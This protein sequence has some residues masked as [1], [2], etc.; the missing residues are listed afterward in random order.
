[1][2]EPHWLGRQRFGSVARPMIPMKF[3]TEQQFSE[4]HQ[5]NPHVAINLVGLALALVRNGH[6]RGSMTMLFNVL[7][8]QQMMDTDDPH[9]EFK[10]NNN[11]TPYYARLITT[12]DPVLEGFFE[13]RHIKGE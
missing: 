3:T 7:R 11:Y 6:K 8:W 1:M 2:N 13:M 10:L 4:F 5:R 9:S 12:M